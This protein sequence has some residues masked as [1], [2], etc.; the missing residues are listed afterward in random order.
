MYV[1][2]IVVWKQ[3]LTQLY[4]KKAVVNGFNVLRLSLVYA[5]LFHDLSPALTLQIPPTNANT[6][7]STC[8]CKHYLPQ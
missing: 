8:F 6:V 7:K 3:H 2:E 5:C 1:T 4:W